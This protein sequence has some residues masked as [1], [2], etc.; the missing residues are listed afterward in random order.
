MPDSLSIEKVGKYEK[1]IV[2]NGIYDRGELNHQ[3]T[4]F[5]WSAKAMFPKFSFKIKYLY[6]TYWAAMP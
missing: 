6:T 3:Y 1:I 2:G 5:Q 4:I